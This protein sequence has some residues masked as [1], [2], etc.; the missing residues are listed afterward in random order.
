MNKGEGIMKKIL[1]I[2]YTIIAILSVIYIIAMYI[3]G[4]PTYGRLL[5]IAI[6]LLILR[7]FIFAYDHRGK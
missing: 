5:I 6:V 7:L 1:N 3:L 4:T 2:I